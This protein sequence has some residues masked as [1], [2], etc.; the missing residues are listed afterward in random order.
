MIPYVTMRSRLTLINVPVLISERNFPNQYQY[1][2][3]SFDGST[4]A[5]LSP[6]MYIIISRLFDFRAAKYFT[7]IFPNLISTKSNMLAIF[8]YFSYTRSTK[9]NLFIGN[10]WV[11]QCDGDRVTPTF[12]NFPFGRYSF[13]FLRTFR[14]Y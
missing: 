4:K 7:N 5:C 8:N 10:G 1:T 3:P 9:S 11:T 2:L 14:G 12:I 13:I 6:P